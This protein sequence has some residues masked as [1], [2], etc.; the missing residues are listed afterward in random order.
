MDFN[1]LFIRLKK[2]FPD[3]GYSNPRDPFSVLIS[4]IISQRTRDEQTH[5]AAQ[6]LLS[7]YPTARNLATAEIKDIEKLIKSAGFYHVKA[8]K[9]REVSRIILKEYNGSIPDDYESLIRLPSVGQKTAN[10]VLVFGFGKEAIPVDT[11]V[12]RISNRL[13]IIDTKTPEESEQALRKILPEKYWLDINHLFVQFGR[14]ICRPI[15]PRCAKC[16]VFDLC[17]WE[18]RFK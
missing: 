5:V 1:E 15:G 13:G 12:H 6:A 18:G 3:A 14:N 8:R 4:T 7:A 17:S 2:R 9:V 16:P 11:H 10:C